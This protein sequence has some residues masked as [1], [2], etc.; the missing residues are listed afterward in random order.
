MVNIDGKLYGGVTNVGIKPTVGS[1]G[2]L[3]ET[4]I[5]DYSGDLYGKMVEVYFFRFVRPERK[6]P[7]I[8]QLKEQIS[9]DKDSVRQD[10]AE[11]IERMVF[12]D[13]HPEDIRRD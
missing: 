9:R 13:G 1:D 8:E 2:P 6:F 10:I 7:S 5:M 4:Y 12:L 11:N 3:A